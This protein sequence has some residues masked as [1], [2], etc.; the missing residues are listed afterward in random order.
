MA[1]PVPSPEVTAGEP[2][3]ADR[4]SRARILIADDK[5]EN[6]LLL[7]TYLS[8]KGYDTLTAGD[9]HE[10]VRACQTAAPDLIIMD[11][12]MPGMD[13]Y[14][15]TREIRRLYPDKWIPILFLSA[16]DGNE[17]QARG[18]NAGGDDYL[19]KPVNLA[20]LGEKIKA[21]RRIAEA[22]ER[23]ARYAS[24]LENAIEQAHAD[25]EFAKHLLQRI[26]HKGLDVS[27]G[28]Q[29]WVRP[30]EHFSGDVI[31]T[32]R[33]PGGELYVLLADATGHGL[34]A[35]ISVLPIIEAFYRLAEKGF[36]VTS[37]V[38]ELNRKTRQLMPRDRFIA[39]A[40]AVIDHPQRSLQIW[41]GGIPVARFLDDAG[42]IVRSWASTHPPLGTLPDESLDAAPQVFSWP[43]AGQLVMHT[44]GLAEAVDERG[45]VFGGTR[46]WELLAG[47]RRDKRFAAL[48]NA[49]QAHIGDGATH[50]DISLVMVA[51]PD[52][53]TR[54]PAERPHASLSPASA[55]S[56]ASWHLS[57]GLEAA[58]LRT[59]DIVPL[60]M[61]WLDQL[62]LEEQHRRTAFIVL[63]EL[64]NN[65]IDHG[66]LHLDS[67]IKQQADGFERYIKLR[68][69]RL[70][71]LQSGSLELSIAHI[72]QDG[73]PCLKITVRDSGPGFAHEAFLQRLTLP[74]TLPSGR[75]IMLVKT[76]AAELRY[77]GTG[78]EAIAV[79]RLAPAAS[80][81]A[82]R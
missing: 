75:G 73:A 34:A 32:A 79:L 81:D 80:I 78:N 66:L 68:T 69:E 37:I 11:A 47:T 54:T 7:T 61:S 33:G 27:D 39:A 53:T 62:R 55:N 48:V 4:P 12:A 70:A 9:G 24:Q 52:D 63:A 19:T 44:D 20:I 23:V 14:E 64:V 57:L 45:T 25:Q 49:V 50:D 42:N 1:P 15:A 56:I 41:N 65:A 71:N 16:Y 30:A 18:L 17:H 21:M 59:L 60:L 46:V 5:P 35:A 8:R 43:G 82:G 76:I 26:I 51:C 36:S 72:S 28:V 6:L 31:V 10:A 77:A 40:I 67:A 2:P 58:Q 29:Q 38:G 22:Q 3:P 13:G 74:E